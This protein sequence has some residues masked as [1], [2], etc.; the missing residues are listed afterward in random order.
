MASGLRGTRIF[1]AALPWASAKPRDDRLG[2]GSTLPG[3]FNG[4][5]GSFGR[6]AAAEVPGYWPGGTGRLVHLHEDHAAVVQAEL[7]QL[8]HSSLA[9]S[10]RLTG[11]VSMASACLA[12]SPRRGVSAVGRLATLARDHG[13]EKA[14]QGRMGPTAPNLHS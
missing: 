7:D 5:P 4:L 11:H 14:V 12:S 9:S 6:L 3:V 2:G 10:S 13:S 1:A 8:S